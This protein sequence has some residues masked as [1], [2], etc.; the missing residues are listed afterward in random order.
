[1]ENH[2]TKPWH[3]QSISETLRILGTSENGLRD[4]EAA[5][6]LQRYGR[7][8]LRRKQKKSVKP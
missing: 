1:M 6:R 7:N 3:A 2:R 8:M 4:A 5:K